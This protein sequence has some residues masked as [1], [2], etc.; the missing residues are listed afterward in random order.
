M[1][2]AHL[3][4]KYTLDLEI[5]YGTAY[6]VTYAIYANKRISRACVRMFAMN[7]EI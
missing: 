7:S 4:Y 6:H 3:V 2:S 1:I 5:F